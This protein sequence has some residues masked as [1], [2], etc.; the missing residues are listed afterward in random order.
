MKNDVIER[1][2]ILENVLKWKDEDLVK[3][4]TGVRRSGKSTVL[5]M[6]ESSLKVSGVSND[7]IAYIDFECR[8]YLSL[9][10]KEQVW[11]ELDRQLT[12]SGKKYV[13]L[14][15][16]QRVRDFELLVDALYA[17]KQ[18]DCYLTGSNAWMLSGELAT[19]LSGRYVAIHV[20]PLSFSEYVNGLD[21]HPLDAF[22]E[23]SN[24]GSFPFVRKM[25]EIG[26]QNDVG[27]Y[28]EGIFN[29]VL[30]KDVALRTKMSDAETL[31]RISA[32]L[33][34]NIG[35]L[36]NTKRISDG[37]TSAGGKV[38]YPSVVTYLKNLCD[39]FLFYKCERVDVKGLALL[40]T[41]A[42]YYAVDTGLRYWM[43]GNRAGDNG[44]VLENIV[45][46]ELMRNHRNVFTV[47][48]RNGYEVDFV[49]RDGDDIRYYQ[50]AE[51]VKSPET[52]ERELRPFKE[53]RDNYPKFLITADY[54][55]PIMHE[56]IRQISVYD[57]LTMQS[58]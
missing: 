58:N 25:V 13:L 38:S 35:N 51:S 32:Y 37:L 34:D 45:Y 44:R 3:V 11:E 17:D 36:T 2:E 56:G 50:V 19:Y 23:Y 15:E 4:I 43:N 12:G 49:T 18:Y 9:T 6:I 48:T 33:F 8:E 40:K 31:Q 1:K 10:T 41:G 22:T 26:R 55:K 46:L 21:M 39:A 53:I 47:V 42:K 14:D 52:L 27:Q 16:V 24:F 57:F 54:G 7:C 5:R 28:L 20:T 30:L 29:T